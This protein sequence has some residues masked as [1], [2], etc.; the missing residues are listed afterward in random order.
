ME[1]QVGNERRN[2]NQQHILTV[3]LRIKKHFQDYRRHTQ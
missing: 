1:E 2:N 3:D